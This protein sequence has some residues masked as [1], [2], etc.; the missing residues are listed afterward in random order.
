MKCAIVENQMVSNVIV[1]P[2]PAD[3][4]LGGLCVE[5]MEGERVSIGDLYDANA[6]PRFI[7]PPPQQ[8]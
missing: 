7:E 6:S 3:W 1:I 5:V 8:E 4:V 2:S